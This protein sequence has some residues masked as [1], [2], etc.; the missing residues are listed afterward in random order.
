MPMIILINALLALFLVPSAL[1]NPPP[2]D[3]PGRTPLEFGRTI[4][5][6]LPQEAL[7]KEL[8]IALRDSRSSR[9]WPG[10]LSSVAGTGILD[11]QR[12]AVTYYSGWFRF[13]YDYLVRNVSPGQSFRYE[14]T[15]RHPF[16]GGA[17]VSVV[18]GASE[19]LQQLKWEGVYW[20]D[21]NDRRGRNFFVDFSSR[22][23]QQLEQNVRQ[24]E[25]GVC[26]VPEQ[27][28]R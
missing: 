17:T 15:D 21:S 27:T 22:F 11:G 1:G 23:F 26:S 24:M 5:S 13:T 7:W 12:I 4:D 20:I 19:G 9:I 25:K 28:R 10:K 16:I 8:D 6:C 3:H 2:G 14:A 18:T